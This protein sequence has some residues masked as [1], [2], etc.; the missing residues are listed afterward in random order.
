MIVII[1]GT[2]AGTAQSRLAAVLQEHDP[3]GEATSSFDGK[4]APLGEIIN[5]IASVGLL[6]PKRVIVVRDLLSRAKSGRSGK[7]ESAGGETASAIDV[8]PLFAAVPAINC[9]IL[10]DTEL[11]TIPAAVRKQLPPD[12]IVIEAEPPRGQALIDWLCRTAAANDSKLDPRTARLLAERCF[13]GTW[14]TKPSNPL[15]DRPPDIELLK[16][17]VEKLA[18]CAYPNPISPQHVE[19]MVAA[20]EQ[21][22]L[23]PFVE[24][25]TSGRLAPALK[26]LDALTSVGD[27]PY[28]VSAQVFQQIE[29]AAVL[30]AAGPR[31]D[32][33]GVGKAIGLSNPRRMSALAAGRRGQPTDVTRQDIATAVE[34]DRRSKN[35]RLRAGSDVLYEMTAAL[36]A[37]R[38]TRKRGD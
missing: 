21:D 30:D 38:A 27:D 28:R 29:L 24:A 37:I 14:S 25:T 3:S 19:T 35:G 11:S 12:A 7:S 20:K 5:A 10:V 17:E 31:G 1:Y 23:F 16:H 4:T 32:P 15:Y 33:A 26:E 8:G 6:A 22:R 34:V 13:P 2:D 9:L 36:A 18:L